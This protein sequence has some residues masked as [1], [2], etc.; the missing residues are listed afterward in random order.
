MAWIAIK[1]TLDENRQALVDTFVAEL[2][3]NDDDTLSQQTL[4][5][6]PEVD[7]TF[8]GTYSTETDPPER[9]NTACEPRDLPWQGNSIPV[10]DGVPQR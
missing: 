6:I 10:V 8:G 7:Q 4:A 3:L 1:V 2:V 9:D 5:I